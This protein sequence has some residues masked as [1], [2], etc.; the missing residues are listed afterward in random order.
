MALSKIGSLKAFIFNKLGHFCQ[1]CKGNM[2]VNMR[3]LV[4]MGFA[5]TLPSESSD[6]EREALP[7]TSH[8]KGALSISRRRKRQRRPF[9]QAQWAISSRR[10]DQGRDCG[11]AEIQRASQRSGVPCTL[12]TA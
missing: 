1:K 6:E 2:R 9:W 11:A 3:A 8:E 4:T 7:V 10:A 5:A 12:R